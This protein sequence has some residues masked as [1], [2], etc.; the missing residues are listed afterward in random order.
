[1]M[2]NQL[3]DVCIG[4]ISRKCD[5]NSVILADKYTFCRK[6]LFRQNNRKALKSQKH[7]LPYIRP[8]NGRNSSAD[9]LYGRSLLSLA[10]LVGHNANYSTYEDRTSADT[11]G[12]FRLKS[13]NLYITRTQGKKVS[14][15]QR[16]I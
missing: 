8:N 14:L 10:L 6:R 9:T 5:R 11:N 16:V 7:F 2:Q 4:Q 12:S 3:D 13:Q 1:M 15:K